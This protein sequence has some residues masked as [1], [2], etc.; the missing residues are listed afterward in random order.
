MLIISP[1][2]KQMKIIHT[3]ITVYVLHFVFDLLADNKYGWQQISFCTL[4]IIMSMQPLTWC[5]IC[6]QITINN[7]EMNESQESCEH[8][9]V[10]FT[11]M[12]WTTNRDKW[13]QHVENVGISLTLYLSGMYYSIIMTHCFIHTTAEINIF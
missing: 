5:H 12:P 13:E 3:Y 7:V 11:I 4:N 9:R 8:C 10:L 2:N 1:L 6:Q